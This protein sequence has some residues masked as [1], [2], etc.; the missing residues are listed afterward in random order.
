MHGQVEVELAV[1][2]VGG[3]E[4]GEAKAVGFD[5]GEQGDLEAEGDGGGG[6]AGDEVD[7]LGAKQGLGVVA[8]KLPVGVVFAEAKG[9][10]GGVGVVVLN[11]HARFTSLDAAAVGKFEGGGEFDGEFALLLGQLALRQQVVGQGAAVAADGAHFGDE[12]GLAVTLP[13]GGRV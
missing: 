3:E 12:G 9:L 10:D 1:G 6:E 8:A 5:G 4:A 13:G 2:G 11:L 7:A